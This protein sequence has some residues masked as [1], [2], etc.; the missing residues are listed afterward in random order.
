MSGPAVAR[1]DAGSAA[2]RGRLHREML[3]FA[4]I[5]VGGAAVDMTALALAMEGAGMNFYA[6]RL[7]SYFCAATFTWYMNRV[8]TFRSRGKPGA[9]WQWLSF[10]A[11]NGVG[12]AVN[13]GT[14]SAVVAGGPFLLPAALSPLLPLLPYAAVAAGS[15]AGMTF[16]F[17]ASKWLVFRH[18]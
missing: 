14:S 15:L 8:F 9:V 7:V 18:R 13:Y 5:G 16:N 17:I 6:G 1:P 3:T 10:L 4:A 12:G 11:A 2:G